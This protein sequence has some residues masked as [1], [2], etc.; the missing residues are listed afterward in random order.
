MAIT[1]ACVLFAILVLPVTST[2]H[3]L[4]KSP[5]EGGGWTARTHGWIDFSGFY[6]AELEAERPFNWMSAAGRLRLLRVDRT[7]PLTLSLWVQPA[8]TSR[9]V[10]L[11]IAVDGATLPARRLAPGSQQVDIALPPS[12]TTRAV[13]GLA[14]SET[15]VPGGS[16]ARS[17]GLRVDGIA[18]SPPNGSLRVP[19]DSLVEAIATGLAL[20][21]VVAMLLGAR[22]L[23]FAAGGL[24]AAWFGFLLTYDGAFLGPYSDRVQVIGIA[25]ALAALLLTLVTPGSRDRWGFR[26]AACI[27][28]VVTACK[29]ALFFHPMVTVGDSIFHVHRAQVVQ[30]GEYFF[31]SITPRPFFEFPY[32]PGLYVVAGPL[33]ETF[34]SEMEHVWLLRT[35]VLAAEALL[36]LAL[37]GLVIANWKKPLAA[38]LTCTI[39]LLLPVGFYTI[40]TSN[41]TNSFGQSIFGIGIAALLCGHVWPAKRWWFVGS[42]TLLVCGGFL[43]HFS[44]FSVGGPLLLACAAAAFLGGQG[45]PRRVAVALVLALAIASSASIA[46]Y[47]AHFMPVY[48]RT[49]ERVLAREGEAQQRSM[50]APATLKAERVATTIWTEFGVA[51]LIAAAIGAVLLL[52]GRTHDPLT[53]ALAGWAAVV[54]GFWLLGI[55]TAVEMRASLAAQPVAAVAAA[56]ALARAMDGTPVARMAAAA[57]MASILLH[58]LS[59]W[60]MCLGLQRFWLV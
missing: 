31:T 30:R 54:L 51:V 6:P 16:D 38:F 5:L 1:P 2:R 37:Y 40:C 34:R 10:D 14:I 50:V 24:T 12:D 56:Y 3:G 21:A 39:A 35:I 55:V 23:A 53:L 25:C 26:A 41:L 9:P 20:G 44:T 27:A 8:V 17:L 57:A 47:Y 18:L 59:D 4:S 48:K 43:S 13:I 58:A 19:P 22:P 11:T 29:L 46:L 60:I 28:V 36:A 49:A 32:P 45:P 42:G 7:A 33:W 15:L 52:R